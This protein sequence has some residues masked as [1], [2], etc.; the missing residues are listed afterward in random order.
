MRIPRFSTL[1]R[2]I[3]RH[4]GAMN[5]SVHVWKLGRCGKW[6]HVRRCP[7]PPSSPSC[8]SRICQREPQFR[9]GKSAVNGNMN[10][11]RWLFLSRLHARRQP[12]TTAGARSAPHTVLRELTQDKRSIQ[13]CFRWMNKCVK[14]SY[15]FYKWKLWTSLGQTISEWNTWPIACKMMNSALS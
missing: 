7:P 13:K 3:F 9:V 12:Q 4:T 14:I 6:A 8:K 1:Q 15:R 2:P 5:A 11:S 10:A